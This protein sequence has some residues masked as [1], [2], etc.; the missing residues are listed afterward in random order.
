LGSA[1]RATIPFAFD[2]A[3]DYLVIDQR[4]YRRRG[5]IGK[6]GYE[7]GCRTGAR[8]VG[9]RGVPSG[10][11]EERYDR[12][13]RGEPL[14]FHP[15]NTPGTCVPSAFSCELP[16][17]LADSRYSD[18]VRSPRNH[19]LQHSPL[20]VRHAAPSVILRGAKIRATL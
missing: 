16:M 1:F 4:L 13:N 19:P 20:T 14:T 3:G 18:S 6:A 17:D 11:H 15:A 7:A 5:R 9:G 12:E 2:G 10:E 8:P